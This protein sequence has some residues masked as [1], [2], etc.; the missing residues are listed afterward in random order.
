M[1]N[2]ILIAQAAA[3]QKNT[4]VDLAA[5]TPFLTAVSGIVMGFLA[6][7]RS[8]K[9]DKVQG[10]QNEITS[11]IQG[12]TNQIAAYSDIVTSLQSEVT[13]LHTQF[14]LDRKEWEDDKKTLEVKITSL[15]TEIVR[16]KPEA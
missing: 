1:S 13:R 7:R 16:I 6:A 4:G 8:E 2:M 14:D 11:L 5:L 9:A 10:Q 3:E 15:E 12:Y